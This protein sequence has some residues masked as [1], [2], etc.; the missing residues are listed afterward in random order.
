MNNTPQCILRI[1]QAY[2]LFKGK[3]RVI[4]DYLV[5]NPEKI[6]TCRAQEIAHAC[7][8]DA[9]RII[10]FCQKVG[11]AGFSA[12]K[13]SIAS[14]LVPVEIAAADK[15]RSS[16]NAFERTRAEFTG[17][18]LRVIN[19]TMSLISKENIGLAVRKLTKAKRIQ[20]LGSGMSGL[21][22]MDIM[23]KLQ[24]MGF[25]AFYDRDPN[26]NRM[27]GGLV[28]PGD[29]VIALSFSGET[30]DVCK[31]A[32]VCRERKAAIISITNSPKSKL[33]MLSD[34]ALVTAS[35][36]NIFRIGAMTSRIAQYLVIDFLIVSLALKNM[37]KAEENILRTHKMLERGE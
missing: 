35:D 25:N 12:M 16:R 19:D 18:Y 26:L 24:R 15:G 8:C 9:S 1:R 13:T 21:A 22:A 10:R 37:N 20:V 29:V 33:A 36:E 3:Y 23:I 32:G 4:A 17:N 6:I 27:L 28:N 30:E 31:L 14:E 34:I 2:P 7:S 11:Y 5:A